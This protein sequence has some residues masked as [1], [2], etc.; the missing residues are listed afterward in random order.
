MTSRLCVKQLTPEQHSRGFTYSLFLFFNISI[1]CFFW[2][3]VTEC[4]V[5]SFGLVW[6]CCVILSVHNKELKWPSVF[7][8]DGSTIEMMYLVKTILT[9]VG[10]WRCISWGSVTA[11]Q[12]LSFCRM[13]A[14]VLLLKVFSSAR[15]LGRTC[16]MT[17]SHWKTLYWWHKSLIESWVVTMKRKLRSVLRRISE[18]N[19]FWN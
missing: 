8:S 6:V 19:G 7:F 10:V 14:F 4:S 16:V 1:F 3:M 5:L 15:V 18:W 2:V 13:M 12:H 11:H 17:S 9:C